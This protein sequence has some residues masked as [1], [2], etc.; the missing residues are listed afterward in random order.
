MRSAL[1]FGEQCPDGSKT[2]KPAAFMTVSGRN[3]VSNETCHFVNVWTNTMAQDAKKPVVFWLHGGAWIMGGSNESVVYEGEG[4]CATQDIVFV[5][6]NH[7]LNVLGYTDLSA[8]GD[9]YEHSGNVGVADMVLALEWV[10]DNIAQFGGD[11]DN[12]TIIGQSGGGAK[13]VVLMGLPA[14][15]GLFHRAVIISGYVEGIEK[16]TARAAGIALVEKTK[17]AHGLKTDAQAL[18]LL[19]AMPYNE[20]FSL[21]DGTGVGKGPVVDGSYYPAKTYDIDAGIMSDNAK[22]YPVMLTTTFGE[23]SGNMA[24]MCVTP[25]V[26]NVSKAYADPEAYIRDN[27]KCFM[28]VEQKNEKIRAKFGE[29]AEEAMA[30]FHRAYPGHE[31]IDLVYLDNSMITDHSRR[32]TE[33]HAKETSASVYRAVFAYDFP[34]FGGTVNWHTGGDLPLLFCALHKVPFL[35]AGD[36]ETAE[37][38]EQLASSALGSFARTGSPSHGEL[39]WTAYSPELADTLV[40]DRSC[41]LRVRHDVELYEKYLPVDELPF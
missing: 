21:S 31:D 15:Q 13:A 12:V 18:E 38:L 35:I 32:M 10:R 25:Y 41:E 33:I 19:E 6:M 34:I 40:I 24:Q 28:S 1:V 5:S 3:I 4:L 7:R 23:M 14:A 16:Q 29:H 11:P 20:L 37:R 8:Y 2:V 30:A 22:R 9:K 27:F 26:N 36:E 17:A 39:V